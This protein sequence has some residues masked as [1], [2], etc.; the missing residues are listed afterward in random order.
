MNFSVL[1]RRAA[2]FS[3]VTATALSAA[4]LA[5]AQTPVLATATP[6]PAAAANSP[7]C[8][9]PAAQ[10]KF[11]YAL[12]RVAQRLA[13]GLPIKIVAVGSSSTFGAGASSPAASYP[14]RLAVELT[15]LFPGH[16]F[17]VVNAGVNGSEASDML[18]RFETSVIAEKPDLV[19]WQAGTNSV[20]RGHPL[21]PHIPLLQA[22]IAKLKTIGA[23]IVLIDPQYA[24][25][26]LAKPDVHGMVE[27]M[28]AIAK[29]EN[30]ELFERFA[31]MRHWHEVDKLAF[32]TF[33]SP[34]QLHLNDWSYACLARGLG[35]AIAEAASRPQATASATAR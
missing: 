11:A 16:E 21:Q 3:A 7:A 22:G 17:S 35:M 32:D 27:L 19:L 9:I 8:I 34:D 2:V 18:A 33:V 29:S 1:M 31:L 14:S 30:V 26:V 6:A 5:R 13:A 15:K 10:A 4:L 25:R 24:P 23:D 12:P 20:L 28:A